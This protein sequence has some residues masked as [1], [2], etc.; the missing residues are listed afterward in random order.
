MNGTFAIIAALP[1]ELNPFVRH[2][3]AKGWKRLPASD[4]VALWEF[5]HKHGRWLA[6]CAGMGPERAGVAF[7]EVLRYGPID[8]VCS[9]GLAGALHSDL[10]VGQYVGASIVVDTQTGERFRPAAWSL[11]ETILVSSPIIASVKEKARLAS[12]Y[13]AAAVDMEAATIARLAA[14]NGMPFY[15]SKIVSESSDTE[16]LDFGR[17]TNA[18]GQLRLVPLIAYV[19]VRPWTWLPLIRLGRDSSK[20]C[21]KLAE[22][23][24]DWLDERGY[25]RREEPSQ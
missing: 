8:A 19:V 15:M 18:K 23:L 6:V 22:G 21:K 12:T 5:R 20:A 11:P 25:A 3:S 4:G 2:R 17:W 1:Q 9:V 24:Y 16:L 13:N 7:A 10:P 14:A